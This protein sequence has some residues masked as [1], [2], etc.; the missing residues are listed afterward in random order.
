M[1]DMT[2]DNNQ[3]NN[4]LFKARHPISRN[5]ITADG[6]DAS[7]ALRTTIRLAGPAQQPSQ[8]T[9]LCP[10]LKAQEVLR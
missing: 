2:A 9:G 1:Y 6:T 5:S 10:D 4:A 7:A 8:A 3:T